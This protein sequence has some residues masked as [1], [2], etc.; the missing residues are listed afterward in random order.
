[1]P[2]V[3]LTLFILIAL[4]SVPAAAHAYEP[5]SAPAVCA[6]S[7]FSDVVGT[8][9]PNG[10][11]GAAKA[12]RLWG[13]G[14]VDVLRG[15]VDRATCLFGGAGDDD[16]ALGGAGG[17][18]WGEGGDDLVVGSAVDDVLYG[19][20]GNDRVEGGKGGDLVD[21]GEGH[22]ALDGGAGNDA[23]DGDGGIDAVVAGSGDDLIDVHDGNPEVVLCGEGTDIVVADRVDALIGCETVKTRGEARPLRLRAVPGVARASSIV[24]VAFRAPVA[25]GTG[26]YRVLLASG[27]K[28]AGCG[29]GPIEIA[30]LGEVRRG[31]AVRVGLRPPAGGWCAGKLRA[32]VVVGAAGRP[33]VPVGRLEF[34]VR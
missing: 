9:G 18:A 10:L 1:M 11:A 20:A 31:Q 22:D 8:E 32:I 5:G 21:G 25:A 15:S 6:S 26:R 23:I 12:Q 7:F 28:A 3:R 34:T 33:P 13:L 27:S 29:E 24:R 19:G 2:H 30:K 17:A 14:G 4:S 16:L